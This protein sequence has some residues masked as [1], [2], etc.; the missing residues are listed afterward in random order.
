MVYNR[1]RW[2][3]VGISSEMEELRLLRTLKTPLEAYLISVRSF[4]LRRML[5]IEIISV[6]LR[7]KFCNFFRGGLLTGKTRSDK[8][9]KK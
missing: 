2:G 4:C 1:I 3:K 5:L 9:R 6:T 7:K 8:E